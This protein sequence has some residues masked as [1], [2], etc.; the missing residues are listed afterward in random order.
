MNFRAWRHIAD[1]YTLCLS[2]L[3]LLSGGIFFSLFSQVVLDDTTRV[4]NLSSFLYVYKDSVAKLTIEDILTGE[5]H[6]DFVRTTGSTPN[7]GFTQSVFWF[8][9]DFV[10]NSKTS[11]QW[12]VELAVPS[13][14]RVDYYV[15][16]GDILVK[17]GK[18]GFLVSKSQKS[19]QFRNP[20]VVLPTFPHGSQVTLYAKVSSQ[21]AILAPFFVREYTT[22]LS[23]DRTKEFLL[24]IYFGALAI[25]FL[26]HLYLAISLRDRGYFWL[27]TLI[28]C[29]GLGQMT[30]VYGYLADWG[31]STIA[32]WLPW[33]HWIN[34]VAIFAAI[35]LS[36]EMTASKRYVP[37]GDQALKLL[38]MISLALAPASLLISFSLAERLLVLFNMLPLPL[39]TFAGFMA[40]RKGHRPALYYLLAGSFFITGIAV[41]NLM[42]GFNLFPFSTLIYFVPNIT[43]TIA[44]AFLSLGLADRIRLVTL[45]REKSKKQALENLRRALDAERK[46]RKL[47]KELSHSR[48]ME[49]IGR[50][51]AGIAHDMRNLLGPLANYARLIKVRCSTNDSI[52]GYVDQLDGSAQRLRE[53]TE[54]LLNT[55]RKKPTTVTHIDLNNTITEVTKLLQ[56]TAPSN[57][58]VANTCASSLPLLTGDQSMIHTALL[59]IGL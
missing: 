4:C 22:Y 12:I 21:T 17:E 50:C 38:G 37:R 48:K 54:T 42:Y 13:V 59:N 58:S 39:F 56:H 26:Y 16:H 33:L 34:F 6:E 1:H 44:I 29:F 41:Y 5:L 10:N 15:V 9:C 31:V 14:H 30:A 55:A 43:F 51:L 11:R 32:P 52:R 35:Q 49:A 7:L 8:R 28:G 3:A 46:G 27:V 18:S 57:V 25:M 36:R 19:T 23:Y 40:I 24:G 2:A 45:D 47:E 20:S 53:L